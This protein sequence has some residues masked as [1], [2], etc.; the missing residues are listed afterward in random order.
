MIGPTRSERLRVLVLSDLFPNPGRPAF[1]I[2]VERQVHHLTGCCDQVVVVPTRVFPPLR[3]WKNILRPKRL[4]EGIR[5]W[6]SGLRSIPPDGEVNGIRTFYPRY[7]S[8]PRQI[9]HGLWGFFAYWFVRGRLRA[10]HRERPFDLVHAHYASPGGVIALLARRWMRAPIVVTVHGADVTYTG[11]QNLVGH[12]VMRWVF[13]AVDL[14]L[15]N[16]T[17]T[18]R[19]ILRFGIDPQKVKIVRLGGNAEHPIQTVN[20][21]K[22]AG[23]FTLATVGYLEERKGYRYLFHAVRQLVDQGY[24]IRHVVVGDGPRASEFRRL[25][26]RL[27]L[28]DSVSFEGYR[29]HEAVWGYLGQCDIFVL[30]SWDEAFGVAYVEALYMGKPAVGCEGQGGPDDLRALGDCIALVKPRDVDSLAEAIRELL[31]QPERRA[32]M[33]AEGRR[34]VLENFTWERT[35]EETLRAYRQVLDRS[36]EE[37]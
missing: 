31:N 23:T 21:T 12:A 36:A 22:K 7:T 18:A 32:R 26:E 24:K 20:G 4:V 5:D 29:P 27:H 14:I 6:L 11:K 19:E 34:I 35:A 16:S 3:L 30:P 37:P 15:A 13:R 28:T 9:F 25:V 17:W 8:P 2:F 33:G 1:G 10:L